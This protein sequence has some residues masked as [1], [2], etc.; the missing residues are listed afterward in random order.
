M[1]YLLE[2]FKFAVPFDK[3]N[4]NEEWK[5]VEDD[6]IKRYES[7]SSSFFER[8]DHNLKKKVKKNELS[9]KEMQ[10]IIS[11]HQN[12]FPEYFQDGQVLKNRSLSPAQMSD[13]IVYG[14]HFVKDLYEY[15]FRLSQFEHFTSIT[16]GMMNDVTENW[17]MIHVVE[18]TSYLLDSMAINLS[19]LRAPQELKDNAVLLINE[20]RST[21]WLHDQN[22]K[23]KDQ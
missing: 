23:I 21:E 12:E 8:L 11:H 1:V 14:K 13:R 4:N 5:I 17:E 15:Y 2:E 6:F 10:D 20:F 22:H 7:V 9:E 19:T 18:V 16:E 3:K